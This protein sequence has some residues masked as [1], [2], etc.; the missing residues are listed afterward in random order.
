MPPDKVFEMATLKNAE[1]IG[2]GDRI[3]SIEPGKEADIVILKPK[4]YTRLTRDNV[5][6]QLIGF[7]TGSWVDTVLIGGRT[8][9]SGG[10]VLTVEEEDVM[11]R[12]R[13]ESIRLWEKG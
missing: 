6:A 13:E 11:R 7:G 4:T 8:V 1:A 12:A 3:G 9:V 10:K 2:M 5:V